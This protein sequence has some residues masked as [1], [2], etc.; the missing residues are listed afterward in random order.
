MHQ[1]PQMEIA[2]RIQK[3]RTISILN[4]RCRDKENIFISIVPSR[5]GGG[6]NTFSYNLQKWL[7]KNK[8]QYHQVYHIDKADRAIIIADKIDIRILE[9]A[10][11]KGCFIIHRLD[12]HVEPHE[13]T[14]RQKK[15]AYIRDLNSLSD[16]TVYQSNFVF[17]NMHPFLGSPERYEIIHNGADPEEFYPAGTPGEYIGHITW[18][19]GDKKRL[20]ILYKTII[21]NPDETFLLIGNHMRSK[22]DFKGVNNVKYA[23]AVKRRDML[24]L[25]HRMKVLFFPSENDPCPNTVI[26]SVLAGVPVCYNPLGGTKELVKDCGAPLPDFRNMYGTIEKYRFNCLKRKDLHFD[27]AAEKYLVL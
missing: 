12:E 18:G 16:V 4:R 21:D 3:L 15:H 2:S 24:P 5:K 1:L 7:K 17:E 13:D 25:L 11:K 6:S 22:Y 10:K 26:E 19:V 8:S 20:D 23:G 14:Y 9:N 27:K